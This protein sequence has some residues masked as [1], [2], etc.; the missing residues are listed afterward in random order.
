MGAETNKKIKVVLADDHPLL[1]AGFASILQD[2]PDIQVVG[3]TDNARD[4]VEKYKSLRPDV[5]CLDLLFVEKTTGLDATKEIIE[6][7]Q[8]A[9]IVILSQHDQD[10]L[11]K[12]AYKYGAKAFVTKRSRPGILIEAIKK[13]SSGELYFPPDI[14]ERLAFLTTQEGP[15]PIDS[16]TKRE[17]EAFKLIAS[18]RSTREIAE[19]WGVSVK[20]VNNILLAVKEKAGYTRV[21]DLTRL[22]L[23]YGV[24]DKEPGG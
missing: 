19:E 4:A 8:D 18:G 23:Q 13:A 5:I 15:S 24:I 10:N 11:I 12:E 17:Y 2:T 1:R 20:T 9:K 7:D 6:Y 3:E 16:F 22:A 14:A 21:A